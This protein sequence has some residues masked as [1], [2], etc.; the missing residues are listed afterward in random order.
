MELA[1]IISVLVLLAAPL[2]ARLV[3]HTPALKGG[4]DGFVVVT[5]LGLITLTLLPEALA[6]GGAVGILI[7]AFGFSLPWIAEFLFHRSEEMTHRVVLLVA[8]LALVVHAA[9]DGAIL[10]FADESQHGGLVATGILLH[11]VGVAIAVW[12]LLRP[13][14][15]TWAGLAVLAALGVMTIVGYLMVV[16]AGE[17]YNIPLVGYW[18]AF[19]AGSLLHVVLHPLE[20]HDAAPSPTTI[21]SHRIGT[22]AGIIFLTALIGSHYLH[23]APSTVTMVAAHEM[24]H[25]VALMGSVGRL[26]APVLVLLLLGI[27][28][29]TKIYGGGM[30][31]AYARLQKAAPWTLAVWLAATVIAELAP[32]DIPAPDGGGLM[33]GLW[34]AVICAILIHTGARAFFSVLMPRAMAHSHEH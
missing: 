29:F 33:F 14:L 15:T 7:A 4:L 20:G 9:S 2:L 8:A 1:L 30:A 10:A 12:W 21:W 25:V 3:E 13:V 31:K 32:L 34:L 17:W 19:A 23:H 18:Q 24:H 28:A 22:G 5:V 26:I 27:A 16:F 6:H 11:R